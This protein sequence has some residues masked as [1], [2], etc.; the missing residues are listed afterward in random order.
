MLPDSKLLLLNGR[1]PVNSKIICH[2]IIILK[3]NM[4]PLFLLILH[5]GYK[6]V[7]K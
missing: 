6:N 3:K 2:C 1:A 4:K 5:L 7:H